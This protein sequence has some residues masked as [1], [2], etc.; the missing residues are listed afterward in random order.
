MNEKVLI[1]EDQFVEA[2]DLKLMLLSAGY[3]VCGIARDVDTA[4]AMVKKE[5]PTLVLVDIFLQGPATGIDLARTL[6]QMG[7]AFI[8]TSAN[9]N[10]E[11]LEAA[12]QTEPYGFL[13]KPYREKDLLVTLEIARY[14]HEN[15]AEANFKKE[16]EFQKQLNTIAQAEAEPQQRL[17]Q[18]ARAIQ[19]Y[20]PFDFLYSYLDNDAAMQQDAGFLRIGF[21][22]YQ[23]LGLEQVQ[24]ITNLKL[25]ELQNYKRNTPQG[26]EVVFYANN[27]FKTIIKQQG[28]AALFANTFSMQGHLALPVFLPDG[29][30]YNLLFFSRR[31]DA[32]N[33]SHIPLAERLQ[34]SLATA[35]AKVASPVKATQSEVIASTE[36]EI[37]AT[38]KTEPTAFEGIIGNSHLLLN[39]FDY[40]TQVAPVDTSVL[41]LGESGTGKERIASC[42][43]N[44]S[45]RKKQPLIKINCAALPAN[46]IES[47][48]FGHEKGAFTGATER[49]IGK[50]ELA[51][52]GTLFL[53]EIG[54]LPL[55]LQSKLLRVL[56][57]KEI[58]RVGGR[59]PI[60]VDVRIIAATNR[61]LE[62]EVGE[63]RFRLDLY[64]RLNIFPIQIPALRDRLD[65]LPMLIDHFIEQYNKKSG[66][67]ITGVSAKVL[68]QF[69]AY[70]WPGNIR[71]LENLIERSIL[72]AKES[73]IKEVTMPNFNT[74]QPL[75][76]T[77]YVPVMSY[78]Q[79]ERG[80]IIEVLKKC[81]GKIWGVG[82]AA[83]LLD[84]P[85][86]T[87]NSKM[88]K[89]DIKRKDFKTVNSNSE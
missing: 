37:A 67:K 76:G 51:D 56:Q 45:P 61:N 3:K 11:V 87:L 1:V 89:L 50:F 9:S 34:N 8:Y 70:S 41:V 68:Q 52:K 86:T 46:L 15:G 19:A 69:M 73:I 10:R 60:K 62:K 64:Y 44:L 6:Q 36:K 22:E 66:K 25:T 20:I 26:K 14:R 72:L 77:G 55:E 13:V 4:L 23:S 63:G 21:N 48:L 65:D 5:H 27:D 88:K 38:K 16:A 29:R 57:E 79:N 2:N 33:A 42:I 31:A 80:H 75:A 18:I 83:E 54:E 53:D 17:M 81:K 74:N 49:R 85:P 35:L 7:I 43:H 39:V 40:I 32:Y 30:V 28:L 78:Q 71:E 12:K 58:E 59:M 84:M 24:I 47:E 82:G